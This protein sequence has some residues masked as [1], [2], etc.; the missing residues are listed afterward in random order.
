MQCSFRSFQVLEYSEGKGK[1]NWEICLFEIFRAT[2]ITQGAF[3]DPSLQASIFMPW[4][5]SRTVACD[6]WNSLVRFLDQTNS[7]GQVGKSKRIRN[8]CCSSQSRFVRKM[9]QRSRRQSLCCV[10][11]RADFGKRQMWKVWSRCGWMGFWPAACA[12]VY[13]GHLLLH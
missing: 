4:R 11:K 1:V 6:V 3:G 5:S 7:L 8:F 9:C 12:G 13:C 10:S 2:N